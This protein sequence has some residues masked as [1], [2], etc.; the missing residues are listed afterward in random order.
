L[1]FGELGAK[2]SPFEMD[3]E[4]AVF[5]EVD[6]FTSTIDLTALVAVSVGSAEPLWVNAAWQRYA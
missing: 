2:L 5:E 3:I 6:F 4:E 1:E